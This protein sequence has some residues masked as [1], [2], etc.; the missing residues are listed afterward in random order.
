[1]AHE[2]ESRSHA[3]E[4]NATSVLNEK[5][6]GATIMAQG[7]AGADSSVVVTTQIGS[8]NL[9][10][11]ATDLFGQTPTFWGR[12]FTSASTSGNV[13]Y[14]HLKENPILRQNGVRVLPIARQ[15]R[16]VNSSQAQGSADAEANSEDLIATFGQ[17]Y[18]ASQ[19]GQFLMFLDVE[20]SPSLSSAYFMGWAQT[21]TAHSADLTGGDAKILPC[22]YATRS[23]EA[24]WQAVADCAE[25]GVVCNGAWIARWVHHGCAALDDWDDVKVSPTVQLPCNVLVWQYSDDCW[26]GAGFDCDQANPNIDVDQ[27]LLSKLVLPPDTTTG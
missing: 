23:D 5:S 8:K 21:L 7:K 17:E 3:G 14:R 16:N 4:N 19:G 24:T 15:T 26:G 25:Q 18:L 20:G 22:V 10:Q 13:E 9:I 11:L 2:G 12:Y 1:M 27:E 6:D